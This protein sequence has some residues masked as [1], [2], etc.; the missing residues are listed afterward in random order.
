[1]TAPS[2]RPAIENLR[3]K[4]T[5][6]DLQQ[7]LKALSDC[8]KFDQGLDLLAQQ[9]LTDPSEQVKQSAYWV[10]FRRTH[11]KIINFY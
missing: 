9:A 11:V 3:G 4:F 5:S 10:L 8:L 1:M 7:R 2:E 6:P